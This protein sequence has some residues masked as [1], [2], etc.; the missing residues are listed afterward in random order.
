MVWIKLFFVIL[1]SFNLS[2]NNDLNK[3]EL[4]YF[5]FLDTN[6]DKYISKE[7]I[8]QATNIIFQ[9]IDINKDSKISL[10]EIEELQRIINILK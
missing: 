5:N 4:L 3:E 2:A 8:N 9:L 10:I 6:N 7:E 1:I